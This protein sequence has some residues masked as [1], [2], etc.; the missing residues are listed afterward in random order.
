LSL[1]RSCK[2]C[3]GCYQISKTH[4]KLSGLFFLTVLTPH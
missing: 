3:I 4:L 2:G 1:W